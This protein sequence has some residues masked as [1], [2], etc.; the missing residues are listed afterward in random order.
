MDAHSAV[1]TNFRTIEPARGLRIHAL[2]NPV[3]GRA[4]RRGIL[5]ELDNRLRRA[6]HKMQ[7]FVSTGP[8]G[9]REAARRACEEGADLLIV[10]GG[11][12]TASAVVDGLPG[13]GLPILM[14]P[15]GTANIL[16]KYLQIR[17]N[18]AR[19]MAII[20]A[21]REVRL[22]VMECTARPPEAVAGLPGQVAKP[23]GRRFLLVAGAGFDAECTRLLA[24]RRRGHI[25]YIDYVLPIWRALWSFQHP[26]LR[27]VADAQLVFEG[28]GLALVGNV[29]NYAVGLRVFPRAL[30]ADGRMD[31]CIFHCPSKPRILGH[32]LSVLLQFHETDSDCLYRQVRELEIASPSP[33]P[34]QLDGDFVGRLPA[35]FSVSGRQARF[36]VPPDWS[37]S[38]C[39]TSC[40]A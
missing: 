19:L 9:L 29:P 26:H 39:L 17:L 8:D 3:S 7:H 25:T 4:G 6:G 24:A 34:I 38:G 18:I 13:E 27:V 14:L 40:S 32:A 16:A 30:P 22:D 31:L 10:W 21:G 15:G 11:D 12:G 28:P 2:I 33:A 23:A 36:L 1:F 37:M 5:E 20:R 35:S